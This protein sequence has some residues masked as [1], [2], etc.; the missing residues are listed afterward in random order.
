M[1]GMVIPRFVTNL[2]QRF[3]G[4][5]KSEFPGA[6][7][8]P[9]V[10]IT[11]AAW[12]EIGE[13][14]V[15]GEYSWLNVN[16]RE[17][18]EKHLSIGCFT[19]V[20]RRAFFTCGSSISVGPY[21]VLGPDCHFVGASHVFSDPFKPYLVT[22]VTKNGVI[23]VGANCFLGARATFLADCEVGYGS[24]IGA[25]AVVRGTIPPLSIAV[26]NPARVIRRFD[27]SKSQW[28]G[29]DDIS[30]DAV[31]PTEENYIATLS[32]LDWKCRRYAKG[33]R[34]AASS[35]LGNL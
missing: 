10:Q 5:R 11:G 32:Q 35:I 15:V 31:F 8:D 28:V 18:D 24:V 22:G 14:A 3:L 20:G 9:T 7:L 23:R 6:Y 4:K 13:G 1:D 19:F 25:A 16:K 12:V 33:V 17:G 27:M 34:V 26:G 29:A 21:C 2:R 30:S